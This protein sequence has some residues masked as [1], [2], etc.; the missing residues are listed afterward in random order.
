[1]MAPGGT[2]CEAGVEDRSPLAQAGRQGDLGGLP[3]R[4]PPRS[5]GL[6]P[7]RMAQRHPGPQLPHAPDQG[8]AATGLRP[9]GLSRPAPP[10]RPDALLSS[11]PMPQSSYKDTA[12]GADGE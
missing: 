8:T 11:G 6:E 4:A 5:A 1:M 12:E 2:M 3:S 7:R 9:G 10:R